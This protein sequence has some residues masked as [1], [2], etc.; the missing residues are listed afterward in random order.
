MLTL[1]LLGL[2]NSRHVSLEGDQTLSVDQKDKVLKTEQRSFRSAHAHPSMHA[3]GFFTRRNFKH[4][5]VSRRALQ[6]IPRPPWDYYIPV[7][8]I[9]FHRSNWPILPQCVTERRSCC[10]SVKFWTARKT[11]SV[12]QNKTGSLSLLLFPLVFLLF[13]FFF[14]AGDGF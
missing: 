8:L 5:F 7:D 3:V 11:V 6:Q 12:A 2:K 13:S 14:S 10:A 4:L 1:D 9:S